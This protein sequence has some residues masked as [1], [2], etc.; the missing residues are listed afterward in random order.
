[1]QW[2]L[3]V[4][5][6]AACDTGGSAPPPAVDASSMARMLF[7]TNV[8]P[9]LTTRCDSCHDVGLN[10]ALGFVDTSSAPAGYAAIIGSAVVG[11]FAVDAPIVREVDSAGHPGGGYVMSE[12]SAV[13][14]WLAAEHS[15]RGL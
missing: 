15:E 2:A 10:N 12:L 1:V 4:V 13:E 11:D 5:V 9:I 7:E 14:A 8:Y 6:L 3:A